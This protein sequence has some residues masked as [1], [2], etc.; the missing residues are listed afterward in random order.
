[1]GDS[2]I[3]STTENLLI[4]RG[5]V[6]PDA[7]LD[8]LRG[9]FPGLKITALEV[10]GSKPLEETV[11]KD[12]LANASIIALLTRHLPLPDSIPNVKLIHTFS[13]GADHVSNEPYITQTDLPFTTSSG[14][15]GPPISEWV[16]LNWLVSS[17]HYNKLYE[18]QKSHEWISKDFFGFGVSDHV[19]KRVGILGYGSIGRQIGRIAVALGMQ[20]IAYTASA[21][22]TPES[23]KDNGYIVP[24]TGD[25]DGSLPIEWHHGTTK[26]ELRHFL[27]T[28]KLDYIVI[29]L[30]LTPATTNLFDRE[31]FDAWSSS[32]S[33]QA[34]GASPTKGF[35]T[36]ISRGK[37]VNTDALIHAVQAKKI[38]GAALDVTD[39]EPLPKE[40]PLWDIEGI[41]ISPHISGIG[42][43]YYVRALD[44]LGINI[45]R[46]ENGEPLI[47]LYRRKRGY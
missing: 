26:E 44:L 46:L 13:A 27:S 36:N 16:L 28:T 20:V 37:I 4:L 19:G 31:E 18:A 45:E 21:H 38:R 6:W 17:K 10:D 29:S 25:P 30:P 33:S 22:D 14:I 11:P 7:W 12:V 39:P 42:S 47:N 41:Q 5:N 34:T 32:L 35:L 24:G 1:M 2:G 15:H 8:G 23:R 40:H 3:K 9:A 43:E